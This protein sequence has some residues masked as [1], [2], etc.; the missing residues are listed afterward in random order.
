MVNE[1]NQG[2]GVNYVEA[3]FIGGGRYYRAICGDDVESKET[4]VR[5]S[6]G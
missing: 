1:F 5:A 2:L 3:A 4:L 6:G